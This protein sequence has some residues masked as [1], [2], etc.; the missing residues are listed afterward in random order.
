MTERADRSE[1]KRQ[2]GLFTATALVVGEV[3]GVGIFLTPAEMKKSVGSPAY[4]LIVWVALGAMAL[5]G[6]LC[7]GELAAR[8]PEAGGQYVYLRDAYGEPLAF[9]YG[10]VGVARLGPGLAAR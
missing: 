8:R 3:V 4:V 6:A 1:L 7:F 2:I 9:L 10:W 5:C